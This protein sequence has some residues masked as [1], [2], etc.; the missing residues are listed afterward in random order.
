MFKTIKITI[1]LLAVFGASVFA[2]AKLNPAPCSEPIRYSLGRID[3]GFKMS[4][5]QFLQDIDKASDLW[6][7][8]AKKPLFEY[9]PTAELKISLVYDYRQQSTDELKK[10]GFNIEN[11]QESYNELKAS[12]QTMK[13]NYELRKQ[14]L[15]ADI[16]SYEKKQS[17]YNEQVA[18]WNSRGGAPKKEYDALQQQKSEL[19]A[20]RTKIASDQNALNDLVDQ[21]NNLVKALNQLAK[22][23]NLNISQYNTIG[24]SRGSQ[25]EEGVYVEDFSGKYIDIF[26]FETQ[27]QL[28]RLLAHELGHAL[29]LSHIED[30]SAIMYRLNSADTVSLTAADTAALG[31]L[32]RMK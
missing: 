29:G 15:D 5:D 22:N 7:D 27:T 30:E 9:D 32:C 28:I 21:L 12:Y 6:S 23:L 19:D 26:E 4:P 20:Q 13:S 31:A 24:T 17:T 3:P 8:A 1:I 18:Y 2:Y 11:N 14:A 25:F 10:L 16:K